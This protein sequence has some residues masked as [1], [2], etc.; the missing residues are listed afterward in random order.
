[1]RR[2]L[3][4]VCVVMLPAAAGAGIEENAKTPPPEGGVV[5][6]KGQQPRWLECWIDGRRMVVEADPA[7]LPAG[8]ASRVLV[9]RR[10]DGTI[11]TLTITGDR[12]TGCL[13]LAR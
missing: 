1:M 3:S 6:P 13:P 5:V 7:G 8:Q 11:T 9:I 2:L 10:D 12:A 4:A